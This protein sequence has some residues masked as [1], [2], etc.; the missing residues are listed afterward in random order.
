MAQPRLDFGHSE[1][2]AYL[3]AAPEL[4]CNIGHGFCDRSTN[5]VVLTVTVLIRKRRV[6]DETEVDRFAV[7]AALELHTS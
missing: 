1:P 6:C 7:A 5:M 2:L 3:T 4:K